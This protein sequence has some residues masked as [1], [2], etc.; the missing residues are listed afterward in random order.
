M[1]GLGSMLPLPPDGRASG[2]DPASLPPGDPAS[3]PPGDPASL[4]PGDPASL[5]PGDPAS[6]PPGGPLPLSGGE[7]AAPFCAGRHA[8]ASQ[9]PTSPPSPVI[10]N[11]FTVI[12]QSPGRS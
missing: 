6:L 5:P 1:L 10:R 2:G 8:A 12:P 3:L 7:L 4:P 11:R 9:S